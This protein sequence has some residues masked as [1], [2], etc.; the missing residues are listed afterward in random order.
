MQSRARRTASSFHDKIDQLTAD[1]DREHQHQDGIADE[2]ERGNSGRRPN[3]CQAG[4][5]GEGRQSRDH[6]QHHQSE[7]GPASQTAESI[8]KPIFAAEHHGPCQTN[9]VAR[10]QQ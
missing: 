3:W 10:N 4:Q 8:T 1:Q 5:D 2:Q 6:S 7:S 9:T